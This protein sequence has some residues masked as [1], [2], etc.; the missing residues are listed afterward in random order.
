MAAAAA[1]TTTNKREQQHDVQLERWPRGSRRRS[2]RCAKEEAATHV[3][4]GE[5][6]ERWEKRKTE[7]SNKLG[8]EIEQ[9][10]QRKKYR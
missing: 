8:I 3:H 1:A 7:E 4:R 6:P 10:M 2:W 9:K 5:R